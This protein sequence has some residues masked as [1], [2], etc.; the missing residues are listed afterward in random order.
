MA[1]ELRIRIIDNSVI[2]VDQSTMPGIM[3]GK[4]S[5]RSFSDHDASAELERLIAVE[6]AKQSNNGE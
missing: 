3:T 4:Q 5:E 2:F 6:R 1:K